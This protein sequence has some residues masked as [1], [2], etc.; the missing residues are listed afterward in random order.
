[1]TKRISSGIVMLIATAVFAG[2]S[3]YN[4]ILKSNDMEL[5]YQKALEYYS[6]NKYEK[7]LQ[8]FEEVKPY[9][10]TRD[11]TISFYSGSA[12]YKMGDFETSGSIFDEFRQQ[13][14]LSPFLEDAEYMYAMG[15]YF[16]SPLPD[17]DQTVTLQAINA[18]N[19]YL[20]HYPNSIKKELCLAR[21][22]ELQNKLFDKAYINAKTYYKIGRYKSAIIALK[23]AI[24][25]Y[26]D[27]PHR[28]ELLYLI[29][30]ASYELA[31]NSIPSLQT[32]RYMDMMDAYYNL[33]SEF[34]ESQY[35]RETDRMQET[36]KKFLAKHNNENTDNETDN[37][38]GN[39]KK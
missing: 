24:E 39:Q 27:S 11:D 2:C 30:A 23:N 8:L 3:A 13:Y 29:T 35:R 28:E 7:A 5:M 25:Q 16:S 4:K 19:E 36:A 21:I 33:I 34:P 32:D 18:I 17:R 1:M 26:P 12:Y 6:A 15:F 10:T 22:D 38:N 31:H 20:E 37:E 14:R 9:F